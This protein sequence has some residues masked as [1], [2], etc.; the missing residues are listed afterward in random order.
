VANNET[1]VIFDVRRSSRSA[2]GAG[3]PFHRRHAGRRQDR[4]RFPGT[5]VD[6]ATF[7][8]HKFPRPKGIGIG[9]PEGPAAQARSSSAGRRSGAARR[10]GKRPRHR[11][12]RKAAELAKAHL[13]DMAGVARLRDRLE[14]NDSRHDR[15]DRRQ[16]QS[17]APHAEH[18]QHQLRPAGKRAILLL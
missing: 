10:H 4:R 9:T 18:H 17:R 8:A 14:Q 5:G 11:R 12:R 7:A 3:V 1:G 16:R 6:C 13:A 2:H 15:S